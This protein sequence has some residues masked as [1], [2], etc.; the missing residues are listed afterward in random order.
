[1]LVYHILRDRTVP[2]IARN[3]SFLP[4]MLGRSSSQLSC[5]PSAAPFWVFAETVF[6][7]RVVVFGAGVR[8]AVCPVG[9]L[10][11]PI[12]S[13]IEQASVFVLHLHSSGVQTRS[14]VQERSGPVSEDGSLVPTRSRDIANFSIM[15]PL[16]S[17]VTLSEAEP[18]HRVRVLIPSVP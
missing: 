6:V 9:Y 2:P 12:R 10:E 16:V 15:F 11:P 18:S 5:H 4:C 8:R 17:F 3:F 7:V 13:N 14:L 1:M